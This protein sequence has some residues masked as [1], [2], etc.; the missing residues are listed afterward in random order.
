MSRRMRK[1]LYVVAG[2]VSL[3]LLL[4]ASVGAQ[5][6]TAD[7]ILAKVSK[8]A[9]PSG[10]MKG[11]TT[12]VMTSKIVSRANQPG[13]MV[14][15]MKF[16]DMIRIEGKTTDETLIR[17]FNGKIGW[18][19]TNKGGFRELKGK[20]LDTLKFQAA[21]HISP[22]TNFKE[23]F[24]KVTLAGE[25]SLGETACHKLVA[26]PVPAFNMQPITL[27]VDK[28]TNML[29]KTDESHNTRDGLL[30]VSSFFVDYKSMD[31]VMMPM[32][33]IS[34]IGGKVLEVNVED[35]NWNEPIDPSYFTPPEQLKK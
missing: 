31:G 19:Y 1:G 13:T 5:E 21:F 15:K 10:A 8:A 4:S 23:V 3:S 32:C 7:G 18:E 16:P 26:E 25:E 35:I 11:I 6:E 9:D 12:M 29:V 24:S 14:V 2:A 22:N 20:E 28:K 30:E 34:D 17:A 27:F 33:I